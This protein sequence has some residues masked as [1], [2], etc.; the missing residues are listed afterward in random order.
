MRRLATVT[1]LAMLA[2]GGTV[3]AA[4]PAFAADEFTTITRDGVIMQYQRVDRPGTPVTGTGPTRSD[5]DGDGVDDIAA[6]GDPSNYDLPHSPTGV[7]AVRYSSA[8]HVDYFLGVSAPDGGCLCFGLALAA[9]DFDGDGFDDLAIGDQAEPH[10]GTGPQ[11][12]G[13]WVVPGGPTGLVLDATRH[14]NQSSPDVPGEP[15]DG[16]RFG[17]ALATG[18]LNGDGRDDLAVGAEGESIGSVAGAGS[19]TVL[20]GSAAGLTAAGA[21]FLDQSQ[22]AVPGGA[23][24]S[25]QFGRSV[26]IGRVNADAFADLIV[27]APYEN[28]G[29]LVEGT[30]MVTLMWGA[31]AGVAAT[32]ATA[33]TGAQVY[34]AVNSGNAV[35]WNIGLSTAVGDVDGDGLGD[36]IVAAPLAQEAEINAGALIVLAGRAAGL[37]ATGARLIN[38]DTAG[39]PGVT[40]EQDLFGSSIAVGDVTGDGRADV[41][42]GA[43]GE[44]V[45]SVPEAGM[46]VLLKGSAGGLTGTGSQGF[47]QNAAAVPGAP[48]PNDHYGASV[49]LLNLNGTGG[50]DA[51]VSAVGE[52]VAGDQAGSPSG[53]MT[54]M[55]ATTS[56]LSPQAASWNGRT[57]ATDRVVPQRYGRRIAAPHS[58]GVLG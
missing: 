30:G 26:A 54:T 21:Q 29:D 25:D 18:D 44:T 8:P 19:V 27:A 47:D 14:F 16:D 10:T 38:Q 12:G 41:L 23:E 9:G 11:A 57:L 20:F 43:L 4:V 49:A 3:G 34:A 55:L 22:A 36:V 39:V 33:V 17:S 56:G 46:V 7:V 1:V 32:G 40:E 58:G 5:F 24:P 28:E 6:S 53:L 35:P 15:E 2:G 50:L 13:V 37:S 52:E 45:G 51:A 42:V 48:E 31:A